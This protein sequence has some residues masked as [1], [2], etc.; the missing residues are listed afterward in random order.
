MNINEYSWWRRIKQSVSSLKYKQIVKGMRITYGVI[1][2]LAL[3]FTIVAIIGGAFAG[4]VG[5]G[6]FASLVKDQKYCLLIK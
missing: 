6:Y 2:N 1:W 3:L 4:G 5:A